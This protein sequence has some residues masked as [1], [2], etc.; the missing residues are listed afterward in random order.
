MFSAS[1]AYNNSSSKLNNPY[2]DG[3]A[4]FD[5]DETEDYASS[6]GSTSNYSGDN[7]YLGSSSDFASPKLNQT[8]NNNYNTLIQNNTAMKL[9]L[10]SRRISTSSSN[11]GSIGF[12]NS[13]HFNN[14]MVTAKPDS[15]I[16]VN[17]SN[18]KNDMG[19]KF[20]ILRSMSS[21]TQNHEVLN[22]LNSAA[23]NSNN[24]TILNSPIYSKKSGS[25]VTFLQ[26]FNSSLNNANVSLAN[27]SAVAASGGDNNPGYH[28]GKSSSFQGCG[29]GF[30]EGNWLGSTT[31]ARLLLEENC[32]KTN[33]GSAG[34]DTMFYM[35]LPLLKYPL[36]AGEAK[37]MRDYNVDGNENVDFTDDLKK[38][39]NH[40]FDLVPSMLGN[41]LISQEPE[42]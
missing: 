25:N 26:P 28:A 11:S 9:G 42:R 30:T 4:I 5:E 7:V 20:P 27:G 1:V 12:L 29:V 8:I 22:N 10:G 17:K 31:D 32:N 16:I 36:K 21:P 37:T 18:S 3:S 38:E 13:T 24:I 19:N 23:A 14:K 33:F 2:F 6:C 39:N 34:Y 41:L 15:Q 35:E 40:Y